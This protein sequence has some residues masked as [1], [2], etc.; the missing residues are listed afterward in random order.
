METHGGST[1]GPKQRS[2]GE[3]LGASGG[4][5]VSVKVHEETQIERGWTFRV[6]WGGGPAGARAST[7]ATEGSEPPGGVEIELRLDWHDYEHWSHGAASPSDVARVVMECAVANVP[8][9]VPVFRAGRRVDASTL[10]RVVPGLD[11]MVRERM[12]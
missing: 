9:G 4:R 2:R 3:S 11:E 1:S 6:T 10:R 5:A 8:A 12:G 7:A